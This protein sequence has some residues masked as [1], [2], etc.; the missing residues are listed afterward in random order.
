MTGGAGPGRLADVTPQNPRTPEVRLSDADRSAAMSALGR[1][2]AEGRLDLTE[3]DSRCQAAAAAQVRRELDVLFTDLPRSV[4]RAGEAGEAVYS[5]SEIAAARKRG[6]HPRA[7]AL[8]LSAVA[9]IAGT[10]IGATVPGVAGAAI[11]GVALALV[12]VVFILLYV[13]KVGPDSWYAPSPAQLE[14]ARL[15]E[16][17]SAERLRTAEKR[18][19]QRRRR[20]ELTDQAMGIAQ[21][22]LGSRGKR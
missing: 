10:A 20:E 8:L 14:R 22:F 1:A 3:Y 2:M 18:A 9:G 16:I 17:Y 11:L 7:A 13:A 19:E 12:P 5:A 15:R 6:Q 4:F 21:N